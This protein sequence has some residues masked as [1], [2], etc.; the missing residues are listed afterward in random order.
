MTRGLVL[1]G[2]GVVGVAW[3]TGVLLGLAEGGADVL[4]ADLIVGT[5]AGAT[6]G[7][8]VTSGVALGELYARQL[9]PSET[10][11]EIPVAVSGQSFVDRFTDVMKRA[12]TPREG[13]IAVAALSRTEPT[14][15][16]GERRAVIERRLPV[17]TWPDRD[18]RLATVDAATGELVMFTRASGVSLVD[19]VAASCAVPGVWPAVAIGGRTYVDGGARSGTNADVAAACDVVVVISPVLIGPLSL[20]DAEAA[21]A[22]RA[23][24]ARPSTVVVEADPEALVAMGTSPLDPANRAPA[25]RAGRRQGRSSAAQVAA[26][27]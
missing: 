5:S 10:S 12:A 8:Q 6:V 27:W 14:A 23:V 21:G 13:R 7:A 22:V 20:L 26:I 18:L 1:G 17:H 11:G 19:A 16:A 2:G 15:S 24:A 9:G 3:E 25:A 4:D